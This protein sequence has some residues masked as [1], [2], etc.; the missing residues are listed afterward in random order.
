ME[1]KYAAQG[2]N[3]AEMKGKEAKMLSQKKEAQVD[4]GK[5]GNDAEMKGK[6]A[7]MLGQKEAQVDSGKGDNDAEMKWKEAKMLGQKEEAQVDSGKHVGSGIQGVVSLV[8]GPPALAVDEQAPPAL[9]VAEQAPPALAVDEQAPPALA[10]AEQAPPA[11]AVAEQAP[12]ALAVAEQAPPALAVAEQAPPAPAVAEQAP[13]APAVAEQAPPAPAVA[14]QAPPAPAVAVQA[15][16]EEFTIARAEAISRI[17]I[18]LCRERALAYGSQYLQ[19][20]MNE[21]VEDANLV[22]FQRMRCAIYHYFVV[23]KSLPSGRSHTRL[24]RGLTRKMLSPEDPVQV[25]LVNFRNRFLNSRDPFTRKMYASEFLD[26]LKCVAEIWV[27]L[28]EQQGLDLNR[29]MALNRT[30]L[31]DWA[32]NVVPP[33]APAP[34]LHL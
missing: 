15:L 1:G 24:A 30:Q 8:A 10:V 25:E 12:P 7:K 18:R 14:V 19:L 29:V 23:H 9:A 3:D 4:S 17:N 11:L 5:G 31:R 26:A 13:P 32:N 28:D 20:I 22:L 2:G 6:E 34:M 27:I 21:E 16:P 33:L